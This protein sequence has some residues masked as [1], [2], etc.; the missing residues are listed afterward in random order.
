MARRPLRR[1]ATAVPAALFC[2]EKILIQVT[3][4][5]IKPKGQSIYLSTNRTRHILFNIFYRITL[6]NNMFIQLTFAIFSQ[7]TSSVLNVPNV[8]LVYLK[9][10]LQPIPVPY[11]FHYTRYRY[12]T[13]PYYWYQSIRP[14]LTMSLRGLLLGVGDGGREG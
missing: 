2:P 7:P 13:K 11:C 5:K 14:L 10:M 1:L 6:K 12:G 3:E 8:F 4:I 9:C